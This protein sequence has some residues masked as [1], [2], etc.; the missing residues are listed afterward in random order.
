MAARGARCP[1]PARL[2]SS[3]AAARAQRPP[4]RA[5]PR[6]LRGA[7]V[8]ARAVPD[9]PDAEDYFDALGCTPADSPDTVREAYRRL[10]K[11]LHPDVAGDSAAAVARSALVNVAFDTLS[12]PARRAAYTARVTGLRAVRSA[13]RQPQR[14]EGLVGPMRHERLLTTLLP[15]RAAGTPRLVRAVVARA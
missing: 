12:D 1:Q 2:R 5:A 13:G 14:R 3:L 6:R 7:T 10:Q 4:A 15:R 9:D 8:A 11:H